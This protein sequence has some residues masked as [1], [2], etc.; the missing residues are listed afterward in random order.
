VQ[1]QLILGA[2]LRREFKGASSPC[3]AANASLLRAFWSPGCRGRFSRNSRQS[4]ASW[5]PI[6]HSRLI[7][8]R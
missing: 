3:E 5:L 8:L 1:E 7:I 6:S 2:V 4:S